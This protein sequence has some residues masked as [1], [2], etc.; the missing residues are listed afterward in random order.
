MAFE[1]PSY[2]PARD[3]AAGTRGASEARCRRAHGYEPQNRVK[4]LARVSSAVSTG[5]LAARPHRGVSVA[6]AH[7]AP[8][9]AQDR[10]CLL[11]V[12]RSPQ[13]MSGNP[14]VAALE[15]K[16]MQRNVAMLLF[17][18][19]IPDSCISAFIDHAQRIHRC[20]HIAPGSAQRF[21]AQRR[22]AGW[23][24]VPLPAPERCWTSWVWRRLGRTCAVVTAVYPG[25]G[26]A[27]LGLSRWLRQG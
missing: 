25:S 27:C 7:E 18:F 17:Q 6:L 16:G 12:R 13:P 14:Q 2:L 5:R 21:R 11:P 8:A 9:P 23:R 15:R 26:M 20:W 4:R 24:S 10:P 1:K 19:G 3:G 22:S